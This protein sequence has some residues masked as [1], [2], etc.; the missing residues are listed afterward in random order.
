MIRALIFDCFGVLYWDHINRM[1]NLVHPD[2][3]KELSDL[4][5]ACDHGFI[6]NEDLVAQIAELAGISRE[7]VAAVIREKHTRNSELVARVE[8]LRGQYKTALLTNMGSETLDTIFNEQEREKL[9]DAV[10]VSSEVG[11]IKPSRDIFEH[12]LERLG[13]QPEEA[14][15]IDDRPVNTDGAERLGMHTILFATN[16]Q[17]ERELSRLAET[18][19]A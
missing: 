14:V 2:Q 12:T 18:Y 8:Q 19:H 3:F 5:H 15:F 11:L 17:F 10:V 1:Y 7:A 13:V 9:F 6:S 4:I 16:A